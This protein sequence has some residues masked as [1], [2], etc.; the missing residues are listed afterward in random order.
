[1]FLNT[2]ATQLCKSLYSL[3]HSFS[4]NHPLTSGAF[5]HYDNERG[6]LIA[7][8]Y[9]HIYIYVM[10]GKPQTSTHTLTNSL[11][12]LRKKK[13]KKMTIVHAYN[14]HDFHCGKTHKQLSYTI[15]TYVQCH[16]CNFCVVVDIIYDRVG[17]TETALGKT[18]VWK[19]PQKSHTSC[20]ACLFIGVHVHNK[21]TSTSSRE[22]PHN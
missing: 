21:W 16:V 1:M 19:S 10:H 12:F 5:Q 18:S 17:V 13:G 15:C 6:L 3:L 14:F 7:H 11:N 2:Q 22:K 20:I 4:Q 9:I 8:M